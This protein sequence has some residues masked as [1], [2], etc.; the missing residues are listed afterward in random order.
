MIRTLQY[1]E[2]CSTLN[3]LTT[4]KSVHDFEQKIPSVFQSDL[5]EWFYYSVV[6]NSGVNCEG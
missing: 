6:R 3:T 2:Q 1:R 4:N 5:V